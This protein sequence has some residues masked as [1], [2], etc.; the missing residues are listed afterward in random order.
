MWNVHGREKAMFAQEK[1]RASW[2]QRKMHRS[3]SAR[4]ATLVQNANNLVRRTRIGTFAMGM[5]SASQLP[6]V[7]NANAAEAS[8][9][10]AV[11]GIAPAAGSQ[12]EKLHVVVMEHA[13]LENV[14]EK[15]RASAKLDF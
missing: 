4:R 9:V 12:V 8:L 1:A 3:V 14:K 6:A 11:T 7:L 2:T 15:L 5:E 13:I 10:V